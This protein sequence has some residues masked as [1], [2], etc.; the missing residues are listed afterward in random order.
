ML[1]LAYLTTKKGY[2]LL[3]PWN[4]LSVVYTWS[5]IRGVYIHHPPPLVGYC[6]EVFVAPYVQFSL[7]LIKV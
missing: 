6:E 5:V 3:M 7:Q 2:C 1:T 4:F